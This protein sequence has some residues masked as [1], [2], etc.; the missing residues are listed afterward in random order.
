MPKAQSMQGKLEYIE[1]MAEQGGVSKSSRH[2]RQSV[3]RMDHA[4][5]LTGGPIAPAAASSWVVG[6]SSGRLFSA[7]T[8]FRCLGVAIVGS[9]RA[10]SLHR[11]Q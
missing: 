10:V 7:R 1:A 4:Q 5:V 9:S 6:S 3:A 11:H 8:G 2:A